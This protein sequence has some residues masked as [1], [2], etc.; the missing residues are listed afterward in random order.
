MPGID[1][2]AHPLHLTY[3]GQVVTARAGDTVASALIN[4]GLMACRQANDGSFRGIFCGM[5][6]CNE[7]AIVADGNPGRLACMVQAEDGMVVGRQPPISTASDSVV[8]NHEIHEL[9]PSVLIV[10]GGPAGLSAAATL[11][12]AGVD[13]ALVEER[14]KLG[15]Q[16]YKQPGPSRRVDLSQLDG[17][18]KAGRILINRVVEAGVRV[19]QGVSVWG[20]FG[21]DFLIGEGQGASWVFRPSRLIL[22]TGAIEQAVP[23]PGW[24]LPGV[25]TT[26]AAQT[27]L[28]SSQVAPGQRV[29]L[30]GNGPLNL[31][32][33]AEL[34]HAGVEVVALVEQADLRWWTTMVSISRLV[35]VAP[36]LVGKGM[37]YRAALA[38]A[39]VPVVDRSS[40]VEIRGSEKVDAAVVARIDQSGHP[41]PGTEREYSVDAICVGYGFIPS[42]E[43]PRA[44][45]CDHHLD[46]HSGSLVTSCTNTGRTSVDSVWVVG[47]AG[48]IRGAHNA[49]S[50]GALAGWEILA[51]LGAIS[52]AKAKALG[53]PAKRKMR[54]HSK[55]QTRLLGVYNA[56]PLTT[57]LANDAT[58]VCRCES[59]PL[60][61]L[62]MA[63]SSGATSAGAAKRVTRAGMGP[64]QGRY[65]TPSIV[66]LAAQASGVPPTEF[67]GFAPQPPVRPL[68]IGRVVSALVPN[69]ESEKS[70]CRQER[71]T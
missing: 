16:F 26:G 36:G 54:R 38:R 57:Q 42:N 17:Q 7:C 39:R 46:S 50:N 61:D 65:C 24:T 49:T 10:G 19:V 68:E 37:A 45:G 58:V 31:Q 14:S 35:T 48:Q 69:S 5:G 21:P 29:L 3:E 55:F 67:S 22:A 32:V 47:D 66:A 28:R 33:A 59:V 9:A 25:M 53:R 52:A 13:V 34:T 41:V 63:F 20:A 51:E 62:L 40:L 70:S 71:L 44:L 8:A 2:Q 6:A 11:A 12:E 1:Q 27:L 64:C 30:S 56:P 4:E 43:I 18:Y 15:G 60:R 23:M